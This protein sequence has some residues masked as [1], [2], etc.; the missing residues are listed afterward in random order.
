MQTIK[1]QELSEK[2]SEILATEIQTYLRNS[3][4]CVECGNEFFHKRNC[5]RGTGLSPAKMNAIIK[6]C[7]QRAFNT[8]EHYCEICK[9]PAKN[10]YWE[11]YHQITFNG[12]LS[13]FS[14]YYVCD[15][16]TVGETSR[17]CGIIQSIVKS[18][19]ELRQTIKEVLLIQ[20]RR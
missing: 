14:W 17:P 15:S 18:K 3:P 8:S 4:K 20:Q 11:L 2:Q 16:C 10:T 5:Q 13:L 6:V 1:L 12:R 7:I 19:Y 9:Q